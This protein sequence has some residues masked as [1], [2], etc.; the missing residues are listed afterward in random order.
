MALEAS[1]SGYQNLVERLNRFPQGAPPS[2]QL[3]RILKLLF[4]EEEARLVALLP[5]R[6]FTAE[7]AARAWG[8]DDA[9]TRK[10]LDD[11]CDRALLVDFEE[12]G[13]TTYCLPPPMAGFFEFSMMRVRGDID[14]KA[15]AELLYRYINVE[16]DFAKALFARG[17]TQLGRVF[18]DEG[19]LPDAFT[20]EVLDYER[21][22][23]VIDTASHIGVSL[24]Y[25]RH[26]MAYLGHACDA[27]R[28][29]CL[30]FNL[31]AA[32]LI[33][34]GNARPVDV[35]EAKDMVQR[36][37]AHHLVQ[38]GENVRE[39]VCFVCNCC[40]CCCEGMIAARRFATFHPVQTTN[41]L[42]AI[43]AG[44]CTGCG[45]C[46][47]WCPVEAIVL[48]PDEADNRKRPKAVLNSDIC[49][50]CG[51]CARACPSDAITMMARFRRVVTPVNTAHRVL[52][53]AIERNTLPHV[54]ISNQ[55][56]RSYRSLAAFLG[57]IFSLPPTKRLLAGR[58]LQSRYLAAMI[59]K[60]HWQPSITTPKES[61]QDPKEGQP[62]CSTFA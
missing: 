51:V 29:I 49:L 39:K 43:D 53:M 18:V 9:T 21:L 38:F 57:A 14:Q 30:T 58:Q 23:R 27:P 11:L 22:S 34:H 28:E 12:A 50:G 15:L 35:I 40:K 4:S 10:K 6:V 37:Q 1:F 44:Q 3:F 54:L 56:M 42:P 26:K 16:E 8:L 45:Q 24:C 59:E 41:Y 17:Q 32:S 46:T 2:E 48:T 20:L 19:Q 52:L 25:C 36:A 13:R 47:Q 55:V 33:R 7:Q 61:T 60:L 62:K 5:I 31:V